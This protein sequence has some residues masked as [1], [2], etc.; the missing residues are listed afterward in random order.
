MKFFTVVI[1]LLL[2]N[3]LLLDTQALQNGPPFFE[4]SKELLLENQKDKTNLIAISVFLVLILLISF[5]LIYFLKNRNIKEKLELQKVLETHEEK[6]RLLEDLLYEVR[7][8]ITLAL[9][10]F[11]LVKNNLFKPD[12]VL[13]YTDLGL[14]SVNKIHGYLTDFLMVS[15]AGKKG[16]TSS[17]TK[18]KL[19]EFIKEVLFPFN[20]SLRLKQLN[21][22]YKSNFYDE[23]EIELD[24]SGLKKIIENLI[25]NAIKYS[26]TNKAIYIQVYLNAKGIIIKI[27]DQGFGF[28]KE[29]LKNIFKLFYQSKKNTVLDGI[30][31]FVV[32]IIVRELNG[33]I[34]V[35]SKKGVGSEFTVTL[36]LKIDD[37]FLCLKDQ[38]LD[39]ELLN[40]KL[41]SNFES[42]K[43][44]YL[45]KALILE[46][47]IEMIPF[48][49]KILSNR[50]DCTFVFNLSECLVEIKKMPFDIIIFDFR[51]PFTEVFNFIKK[52]KKQRNYKEFIFV[53]ISVKPISMKLQNLLDLKA[54]QFLN[55]PFTEAELLAKI[56][57]LLQPLILRK[58]LFKLDDEII[59]FKDADSD[60]MEKINAIIL[61][62]IKSSH[63]NVTALSKACGYSSGQL[64]RIL[65]KKTG[66]T[67]NKIILE[68]RLQKAHELIVN[69]TYKTLNEVIFSVGL[70]SRTYFN[71]VFFSRFGVLPGKLIKGARS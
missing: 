52:L 11:N 35:I 4:I 39:F 37:V 31:L 42:A 22:Y 54:A 34:K 32:E 40:L 44:R 63:F 61:E 50:L 28:P 53:I 62:N 14:D 41:E 5:Y 43:G 23:I 21:L 29:D 68:V 18:N 47:S 3:S 7:A 17:V 30:G 66:M 13:V 33:T 64:S 56:N 57:S 65:K 19:G 49:K 1:I 71:K 27:K 58:K 8:P 46:E 45:P 36:P 48:L 15:T 20:E 6:N 10:Y 2:P 24:Y 16:V 12:K 51:M 59:N 38:Q 9:G 26:K 67:V 55:K 69:N 25:S 70:N 60:L